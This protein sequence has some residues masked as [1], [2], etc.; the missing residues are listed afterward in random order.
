MRRTLIALPAKLTITDPSGKTGS[1]TVPITEGGLS[2]S[3]D[4]ILQPR[5]KQAE[6][7]TGSSGV[8]VV[9]QAGAE[10]GKRVGDI[11]NNDWISFSPM[12]VQGITSVAYRVSSPAGGG[13]IEL[14]ADSPT[15]QLLSTTAVPN[16]GGWDTYQQLAATPVTALSG[17]HPLFL[18]FKHPTA[19]QF[20]LDSLTLNGPGVGGGGTGGPVGGA[21]CTLTAAH[22]SKVADVE[23]QSTL[24]G[25]KVLQWG[26]NGG[27]NQQWISSPG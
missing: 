22:S 10:N 25:A 12:S 19:N 21:V 7:F 3:T 17:S 9:D 6:Y 18:V 27:T 4:I 13:T 5:K 23:G 20:D 24:D 2:A 14:R 15:G 1:A 11:S 26:G 8:R 16:T